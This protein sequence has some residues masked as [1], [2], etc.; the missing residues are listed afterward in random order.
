[1]NRLSKNEVKGICEQKSQPPGLILETDN[2]AVRVRMCSSAMQEW[3][4]RSSS[5]GEGGVV[6]RTCEGSEG[7]RR[8]EATLQVPAHP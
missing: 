2:E 6:Q 8:K 4:N 1:M 5:G 7:L 3:K